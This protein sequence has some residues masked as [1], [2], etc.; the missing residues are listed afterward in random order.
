M[1]TKST[2]IDL[3]DVPKNPLEAT[4]LSCHPA[5][6]PRIDEASEV[7]RSPDS[8]IAIQPM[9]FDDVLNNAVVVYKTPDSITGI[10]R[11]LSCDSKK[12]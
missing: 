4:P 2:S 5:K 11:C 3:T 1:N 10:R 12:M 9:T 6:V 7:P 8:V